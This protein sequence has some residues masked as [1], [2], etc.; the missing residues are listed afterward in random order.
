M[1]N[2]VLGANFFQKRFLLCIMVNPAPC[3]RC[4]RSHIHSILLCLLLAKPG[5]AAY[6]CAKNKSIK[7]RQFAFFA[8]LL[9]KS[10]FCFALWSIPHLAGVARAVTYIVC[11]F[12]CS[13]QN[14]AL[15]HTAVQKIKRPRHDNGVPR[16]FAF[17]AKLSFLRKK[18][19]R[20][21]Y[22]TEFF[23]KLFS[24]KASI[25]PRQRSGATVRFLC[26]AFFLVKESGRDLKKCFADIILYT[27]I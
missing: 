21:C 5:I 23:A 10:V 27:S 18:H 24:K 17:F 20:G 11:S 16:Q 12:A 2:T 1:G 15:P 25:K 22:S 8:K 7:P 26:Q 19:S 14:P 9:F 3:W 13:L 6:C 4:S